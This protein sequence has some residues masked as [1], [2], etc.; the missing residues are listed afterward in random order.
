MEFII[1]DK[2]FEKYPDFI[3][4]VLVTKDCD[5][6]EENEEIAQ[7]L[8]AEEARI[9]GDFVLENLAQHPLV[10]NWRKAYRLFGSDDRCSSEALI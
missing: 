7:F 8:R 4:G 9:K 10:Q 2:I 5:N 6:K 1:S 3:V